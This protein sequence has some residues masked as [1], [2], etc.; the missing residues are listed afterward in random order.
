MLSI[1]TSNRKRYSWHT[2]ERFPLVLSGGVEDE[3]IEDIVR[4]QADCDELDLIQ[5]M[6]PGFCPSPAG[7]PQRSV[8]FCGGIAQTI[9]AN[10]LA[11]KQRS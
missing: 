7:T 9:A 1:T 6:Y 3:S 4:L 2:G 11:R 10:L 5:S 8:H